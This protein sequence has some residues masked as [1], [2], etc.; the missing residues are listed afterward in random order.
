MPTNCLLI[1]WL[2]GWI[3]NDRGGGVR[4]EGM[5][6]AGDSTYPEDAMALADAVMD[7]EAEPKESLRI[8]WEGALGFTIGQ[9]ITAAD[10]SGAAAT[11]RCVGIAYSHDDEGYVIRSPVLELVL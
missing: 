8:T 2:H 4:E 3:E 1:R 7:H 11:W 9:T 10:S 5:L 6:R